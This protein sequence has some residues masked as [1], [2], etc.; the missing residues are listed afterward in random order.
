MKTKWIAI[1]SVTLGLIIL[2]VLNL[3]CQGV[4]Y[5][6]NAAGFILAG[7]G[8]LVT[9]LIGWQIFELINIRQIKSDVKMMLDKERSDNQ[10]ELL[11]AGHCIASMYSSMFKK[12]ERYKV[13]DEFFPNSIKGFRFGASTNNTKICLDN[14]AWMRLWLEEAE[15]FSLSNEQAQR[16]IDDLS[17]VSNVPRRAK[18]GYDMLI[19]E[20]EKFTN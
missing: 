12:G 8:V 5:D 17:S 13:A 14:I 19:R 20:F 16:Y 9:A 3:Y 7:Y 11:R 18:E 2:A 6:N 4:P 10:T 1:W 15:N